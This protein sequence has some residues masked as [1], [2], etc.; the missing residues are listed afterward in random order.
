MGLAKVW[1]SNNGAKGIVEVRLN[2]ASHVTGTGPGGHW[3]TANSQ[4]RI[5]HRT[6]LFIVIYSDPALIAQ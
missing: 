6:I 4:Y 5:P 3:Y 1:E 2:V